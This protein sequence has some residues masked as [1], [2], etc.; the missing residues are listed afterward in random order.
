MKK[1][2]ERKGD[3]DIDR[4]RVRDNKGSKTSKK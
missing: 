2:R 3:N 4:K 1:Q